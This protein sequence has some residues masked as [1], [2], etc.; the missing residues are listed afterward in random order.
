MSFHHSWNVTPRQAIQIQKKLAAKIIRKGNPKR[1][2]FIA[3]CDVAYDPSSKRCFAGVIVFRWPGLERIEEVKAVRPVQFP[4]VPGLLTF[5]EAPVLLD[6][7]KKLSVTPDLLMF[8]GQGIAHPRRFGLAS[9][10]GFLLGKPTIGVAKSR[11]VGS[12]REPGQNRG[13]HSSLQDGREIIGAVVRTRTKVRPIF[14]SVG[15]KI[16]L[17]PAIRWAFK[18]CRGY[19]IPEPTRQADIFVER[20]KHAHKT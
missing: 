12:F 6:C 16:G 2:R 10:L 4:Y 7:F 13:N 20:L 8:D 11:L 5:R 19:R 18:T 17:G 14:V 15:H 3:G 9:H 1:V